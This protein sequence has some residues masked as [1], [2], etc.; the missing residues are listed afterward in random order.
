MDV[1]AEISNPEL[2][3]VALYN[4]G[5]EVNPVDLEDIAIEVFNLAPKRFCWKKYKDRIDLRIVL[6]SVND[7]IKNDIGYIK[8]SSKHGYMLT[9]LGLSWVTE[10]NISEIEAQTSRQKST[11]DII[12][13]EI[14]R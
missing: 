1:R 5:G 10:E 6:Y 8:G 13:K 9:N 7:A 11:I 14:D 12:H 2:V 3:T 4:L